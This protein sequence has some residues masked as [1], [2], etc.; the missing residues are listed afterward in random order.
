MGLIMRGRKCYTGKVRETKPFHIFSQDYS[1]VNINTAWGS[2]YV[3]GGNGIDVDISSLGLTS[4]PKKVFVS[5][6]ITNGSGALMVVQATSTT[7]SVNIMRP[8]SITNAS[9]TMNVLI[10]DD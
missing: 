2:M 3:M 9:G 10:I 8:T 1:N 5:A 6:S 7:V 4:P